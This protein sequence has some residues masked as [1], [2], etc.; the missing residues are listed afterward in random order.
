MNASF[1]EVDPNGS[2]WRHAVAEESMS[3]VLGSFSDD[4]QLRYSNAGMRRLLKLDDGPFDPAYFRCPSFDTFQGHAPRREPVYTGLVTIHN[5]SEVGTSIGASVFRREDGIHFIGEYDVT[6]LAAINDQMHDLN[7]EVSRL[8]RESA[9]QTRELQKTLR[10]LQE[11]QVE[12]ERLQEELM[13]ASRRAGQAEVAVGLLHNV[14]N[15]LNSLLVSSTLIAEAIQSGQLTSLQGVV[16][17]L[18]KHKADLASFMKSSQG[19]NLLPYLYALSGKMLEERE[20]LVD[21]ARGMNSRLTTLAQFIDEHRQF[22]QQ[23]TVIECVELVRLVENLWPSI[24]ACNRSDAV[25]ISLGEL[26]TSVTPTDP[27][28]VRGLLLELVTASVTLTSTT[29]N[30]HPIVVTVSGEP[31]PRIRITIAGL[32]LTENQCQALIRP[33]PE[34]GAMINLHHAAN[35][36]TELKAKLSVAAELSVGTTIIIQFPSLGDNSRQPAMR[37]SEQSEMQNSISSRNGNIN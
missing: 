35:V 11:S 20:R 23:T 34:P 30:A 29:D 36:A 3:L 32:F 8:H 26:E 24:V 21:E 16:A 17:M 7:G 27:F 22:G 28:R 1:S 15:A 19:E 37:I 14:G 4:G 2:S 5:G 25:E 6:E 9:R 18:E 33:V 10:E 13:D 12:R 31:S